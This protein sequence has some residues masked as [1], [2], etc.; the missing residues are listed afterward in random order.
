MEEAILELI[1]RMTEEKRLSCKFP[2]YV[3]RLEIDKMVSAALNKLYADG[4]IRVGKT[5]NDKWIEIV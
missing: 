2:T 3:Q 5:A 4:R 1:S